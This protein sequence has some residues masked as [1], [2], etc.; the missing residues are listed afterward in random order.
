MEKFIDICEKKFSKLV[1]NHITMYVHTYVCNKVL[2]MHVTCSIMITQ[3]LIFMYI[4]YYSHVVN[5][6]RMASRATQFKL[7]IYMY[8]TREISCA[9]HEFHMSKSVKYT[10]TCM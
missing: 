6:Y 2:H 7:D 5:H 8:V 9:T 10:F 1:Y 3:T 4:T